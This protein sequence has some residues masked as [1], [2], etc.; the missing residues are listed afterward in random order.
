[1]KSY[2]LE[3]HY[4]DEIARAQEALARST[5]SA[6]AFG[7]YATELQEFDP[8]TAEYCREWEKFNLDRVALFRQELNSLNAK[9]QRITGVQ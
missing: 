6:I 8:K 2:L 9:L 7:E 3:Q 4:L 5:E 1:M